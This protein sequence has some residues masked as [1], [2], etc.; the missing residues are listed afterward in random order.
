MEEAQRQG[1]C[2]CQVTARRPSEQPVGIW[3]ACHEGQ[4][5]SLSW[6]RCPR[7]ELG[8]RGAE[9]EGTRRAWGT[10]TGYALQAPAAHLPVRP[11]LQMT[12]NPGL[13]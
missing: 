2:L 3:D 13:Q 12:T 6:L 5:P 11:L 1:I 4:V 7:R 8:P 9:W 10:V